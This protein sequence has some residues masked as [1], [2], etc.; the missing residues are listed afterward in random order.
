MSDPQV[1]TSQALTAIG[2]A[3]KEEELERIELDYLGRKSGHISQMLSGIGKLQ[4]VERAALGQSANE[5]KRAIE[6]ALAAR[7]AELEAVRL[8]DLAET[9]AIDITFPGPGLRRGH[10]H[11]LTH[12]RRQIHTVLENPRYPVQLGPE[13]ETQW[14]NFSA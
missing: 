4:P 9:E 1:L 13:R 3:Q 10:I 7:R 6:A 5:A 8:A 14:H 11:A 12:V 2:K